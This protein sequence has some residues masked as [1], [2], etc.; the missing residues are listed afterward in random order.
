MVGVSDDSLSAKDDPYAFNEPETA[1]VHQYQN[2]GAAAKANHRPIAK[3]VHKREDYSFSF[4]KKFI[5]MFV[6]HS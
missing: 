2:T 6:R 5:V 4:F 1:V 3:A